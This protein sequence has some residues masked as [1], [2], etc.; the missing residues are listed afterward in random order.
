MNDIVIFN[1][2]IEREVYNSENFKVYA[3]APTTQRDKLKYNK[4]G[5]VS[6]CGN[7]QELSLGMTYTITGKLNKK[8][9]YDV[10]TIKTPKNTF[11][12]LWVLGNGK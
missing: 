10:M 11:S 8:D 3:V 5:N 6:I 4:Y 2:V 7:I 12:F 9:G 1:A